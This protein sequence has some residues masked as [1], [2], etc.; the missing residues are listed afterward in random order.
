MRVTRGSKVSFLARKGIPKIEECNAISLF[1]N[2]RWNQMTENSFKRY[3]LIDLGP[4]SLVSK[5]K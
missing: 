1:T 2:V 5:S 4:L 3:F